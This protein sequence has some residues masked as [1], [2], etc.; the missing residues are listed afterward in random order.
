MAR[1]EPIPA[2]A[3]ER[4]CRKCGADEWYQRGEGG[5]VCRP[6]TRARAAAHYAA[7][8]ARAS[9]MAR[10]L[11]DRRPIYTMHRRARD[12][13]KRRGIEFA[14][15]EEDI[16]AVW[17]QDNCCPVLGIPFAVARHKRDGCGPSIDRIDNE[18]G[19]VPG[20]IAVISDRANSLKRD[21]TTDEHYRIA[22]WMTLQQLT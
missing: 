3:R 9:D 5:Y 14:I 16:S 18:R 10:R 4:Q 19:Y 21:G 20:N 17:P 15:T 12:G 11:R 1:R 8:K 2:I 22:N 7:N 6:C 13:A